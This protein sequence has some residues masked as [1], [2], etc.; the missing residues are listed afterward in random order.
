M[1]S[2]ILTIHNKEWLIEKVLAGIFSNTSRFCELIL[3][4]DGC[5]DR[6][7]EVALNFC[8]H[9]LP[10]HISLKII[11]TPDVFETMANNSGMKIAS[12]EK[13]MI[14]QDDM[15]IK[16]NGWIERMQKPLNEYNDIFAVTSRTAHNWEYNIHNQH[17]KLTDNLEDC[18]CDILHHTD[19]AHRGN[20]PRN[21]FA[22]RESVNRGPLLLRH[23]ILQKMN[24][25]DESFSPQDMDDHDLC[26]RTLKATGMRA[27]CFWIDYES[28][29]DWGGTRVNG[30][31]ASWM[32]KSNHKNTK[33]VWNRHKDVILSAKNNE[34]RILN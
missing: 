34:N 14:V 20:T 1:T 12:G 7:E 21:V 30:S 8:K 3:V 4:F 28:R 27:G 2:I 17:E 9:F 5:S 11:H 31:T 10:K 6:S 29:D 25:L 24:Y 33:I 19:H 22:I 18:W 23:D 16:E 15:I 26:Y 13:I 32:Y